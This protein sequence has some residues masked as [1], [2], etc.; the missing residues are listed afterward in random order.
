[1]DYRGEN[2]ALHYL[3]TK[4][5]Q[6]VDF[7]LVNDGQIE[8]IIEVKNS[9]KDIDKSLFA[10]H[11]KYHIPAVQLVKNLRQER[12]VGDIH[13]MKVTEFLTSLYL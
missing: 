8:K 11:Q 7:A 12:K 4:D 10:F 5:G 1:M 3:R 13:V 6:E 2:S 9:D